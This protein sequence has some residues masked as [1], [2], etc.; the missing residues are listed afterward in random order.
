MAYL[1]KASR[2]IVILGVAGCGVVFVEFFTST[3]TIVVA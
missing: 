3:G 1:A 2:R